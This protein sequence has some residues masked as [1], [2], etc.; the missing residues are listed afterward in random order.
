MFT[1]T[2]KNC[3]KKVD[4]CVKRITKET[5]PD[6]CGTKHFRVCCCIPTLTRCP[7]ASLHRSRRELKLYQSNLKNLHVTY[8]SENIRFRGKDAQAD[9]LY[10]SLSSKAIKA[11]K[12]AFKYAFHLCNPLKLRKT[13]FSRAIKIKNIIRNCFCFIRSIKHFATL[14]DVTYNKVQKDLL[15]LEPLTHWDL[16]LEC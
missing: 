4:E 7:K 13:R 14:V 10:N 11:K 12:L 1:L 8:Q 6:T 5:P 16:G 2:V 3:I 15:W 9:T